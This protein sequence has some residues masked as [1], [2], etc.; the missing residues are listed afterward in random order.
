MIDVPTLNAGLN[1]ASATCL[2]LGY[3]RIRAGDRAGHRRFMLAALACSATF[4]ASYLAYH[5]QVGSV[6]YAGPPRWR[7]IYLA[8]LASH[9]V[10]AAAV[11]PLVLATLRRALRESFAEHRRLARWTLPVWVYVSI[12]GVVVYWM[13]YRL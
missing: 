5:A 8:I 4:L 3:W 9:S 6:P 1:A 7:G 12:T 11:V 2:A 13:L 10:L